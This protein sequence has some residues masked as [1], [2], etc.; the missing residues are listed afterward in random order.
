MIAALPGKGRAER[1]VVSLGPGSFTGIRVGIAAARGLALAW[2]AEIFGYPTMALIAAQA[3]A[4][5]GPRARCVEFTGVG[6][7]PTLVQPDQVAAVLD[8][9]LSP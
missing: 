4:A 8:F 5:R 2:Q 7:A 6:H 1:I 3:M 9:L